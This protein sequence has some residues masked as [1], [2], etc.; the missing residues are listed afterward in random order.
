VREGLGKIVSANLL[1]AFKHTVV[2]ATHDSTVSGMA[3]G[4]YFID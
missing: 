1:D 3:R 4:Q 2:Q